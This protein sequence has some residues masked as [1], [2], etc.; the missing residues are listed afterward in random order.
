MKLIDETLI[1]RLELNATGFRH[2]GI[3]VDSESRRLDIALK[4][5]SGIPGPVDEPGRRRAWVAARSRGH[6][7]ARAALPRPAHTSNQFAANSGAGLLDL[8]TRM[9]HDSERAAMIYEHEARR[10]QGH[11][12]RDRQARGRRAPPGRRRRDGAG[13]AFVQGS[14][15]HA[16]TGRATSREPAVIPGA[17][18]LSR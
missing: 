5:P 16:R 15:R 1:D 4:S 11:N 8:M 18:A 9:G 12:R 6:R 14:V 13:G 2:L 3:S 10:G 17:V 7:Q